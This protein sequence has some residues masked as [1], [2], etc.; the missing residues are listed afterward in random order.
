MARSTKAT[1]K[2]MTQ[3][4]NELE[5]LIVTENGGIMLTQEMKNDCADA[6][7]SYDKDEAWALWNTLSKRAQRLLSWVASACLSEDGWAEFEN[8]TR[9]RAMKNALRDKAEEVLG[10]ELGKLEARE[11]AVYD[12]EKETETLRRVNAEQSAKIADLLTKLTAET[13]RADR[14]EGRAEQAIISYNEV[15]AELNELN[16]ALALLGRKMGAQ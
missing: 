14:N 10:E 2:S 8:A 13:G 5:S 3:K 12:A 11:K 6:L 1:Y 15:R 4:R 7:V 9:V 16:A